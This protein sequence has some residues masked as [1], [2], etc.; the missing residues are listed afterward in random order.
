VQE[1]LRSD[2]VLHRSPLCPKKGLSSELHVIPELV[3]KGGGV[4]HDTTKV[5]PSFG[6][7]ACSVQTDLHE[8]SGA[9]HNQPATAFSGP[10]S[11]EQNQRHYSGTAGTAPVLSAAL[12]LGWTKL[13]RLH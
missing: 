8:R 5:F 3:C 6:C 10:G 2:C 11:K 1:I 7:L 13:S 9:G 12:D 4:W